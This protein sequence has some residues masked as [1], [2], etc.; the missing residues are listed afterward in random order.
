MACSDPRLTYLNSYG[1]N[2]IKLPRAGIEPLQVLGRDKD[3]LEDLGE[4]STI[5]KSQ[6]P[7]PSTPG[8]N[9][10]M[11]FCSKVR[12]NHRLGKARLKCCARS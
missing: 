9:P 12:L 6:S 11:N 10:A 5:W 2:V 7:I 3:S 1:Y 4:L 8:P